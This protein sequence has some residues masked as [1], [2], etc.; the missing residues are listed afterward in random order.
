MSHALLTDRFKLKLH[1]DTK[2]FAVYRLVVG[3][4]GSKINE[5]GP[6]PG[7]NVVVDRRPGHLSA[8]QMPMSQLAN[9]L[10]R[11]LGRPVLDMTGIKGVID[12][13]LDRAPDSRATAPEDAPD[14]WPSLFTAVQEQPGLKLEAGKSSIETLVVDHAERASEY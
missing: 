12:V 13:K 10:K 7:D 5:L 9:I 3:K 14:G 8:E 6:N 4:S 11:Q 2:D 1:R